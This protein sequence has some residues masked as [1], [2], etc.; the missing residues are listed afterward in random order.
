MGFTEPASDLWKL[1]QDQTLT[2]KL[3]YLHLNAPCRFDEILGD[4]SLPPTL[5]DFH[6]TSNHR[7]DADLT[8]LLR[9]L[10]RAENEELNILFRGFPISSQSPI[11]L[12]DYPRL[13]SRLKKAD[14]HVKDI[15]E[16]LGGQTAGLRRLV[17]RSP[18]YT[19]L[20][21]ADSVGELLPDLEEVVWFDKGLLRDLAM[22]L[23][24]QRWPRRLNRIV[25]RNPDVDEY[26]GRMTETTLR[27]LLADAN[28][29][30][31]IVVLPPA[32]KGED[33]AQRD[34]QLAAYRNVDRITVVDEAVWK[35]ESEGNTHWPA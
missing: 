7:P 32:R 11:T 28:V 26:F 4:G 3:Q 22:T 2:P 8:P 34:K 21:S 23:L 14:M 5:V 19:M 30:E 33:P 15:A 29:D 17:L 31:L 20:F 18:K 12:K 10:D 35:V 27:Q 24:S 13:A 6:L 1:L 25:I 9:M 16:L